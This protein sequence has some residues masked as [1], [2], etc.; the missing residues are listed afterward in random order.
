M[1]KP[2]GAEAFAVLTAFYDYDPGIPLEARVVERL[3]TASGVRRKVVFRSARGF[4]VPAY[5]EFPA[6]GR[7]PYPC[8]LLLHGWSGAKENWWE[9]ENY[10]NGGDDYAPNMAAAAAAMRAA[11]GTAK[12]SITGL[13]AMGAS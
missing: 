2:I 13:A 4:L 9:D 8:V 6:E 5:L 11:S 10:I 1:G 3:D 12:R 7:P